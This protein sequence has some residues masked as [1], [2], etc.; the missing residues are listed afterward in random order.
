MGPLLFLS[1]MSLRALK[2]RDQFGAWPRCL[3][4]DEEPWKHGTNLVHGQ[5]VFNV[6]KSPN[7]VNV[8]LCLSTFLTEKKRVL[9]LRVP[10]GQMLLWIKG[11]APSQ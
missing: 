5:D 6:T 1:R 8:G 11:P 10:E 9:N 7:F 3:Q 2:I 4:F